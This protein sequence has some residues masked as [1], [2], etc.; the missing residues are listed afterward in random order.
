[1]R[2]FQL[3]QLKHAVESGNKSLLFVK[4]GVHVFVRSPLSAHLSSLAGDEQ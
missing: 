2:C 1:M 3:K 4:L